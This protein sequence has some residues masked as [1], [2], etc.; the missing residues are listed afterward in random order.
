MNTKF[1]TRIYTYHTIYL[2]RLHKYLIE[3]CGFDYDDFANH[4][5]E[6]WDRMLRIVYRHLS[7]QAVAFPAKASPLENPPVQYCRE[8]PL[9]APLTSMWRPNF[10]HPS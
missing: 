9:N 10:A 4:L 8:P 5:E 1:N 6:L 3:H 7:F 2:M